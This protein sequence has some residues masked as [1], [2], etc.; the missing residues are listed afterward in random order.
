[1]LTCGYQVRKHED[2]YAGSDEK[3]YVHFLLYIICQ[4]I[5]DVYYR[6]NLKRHEMHN[7]KF[8]DVKTGFERIKK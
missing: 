6:E 2:S 1:M 4:L 3:Q 8:E 5:Y 7:Q